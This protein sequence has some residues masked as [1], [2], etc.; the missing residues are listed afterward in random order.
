MQVISDEQDTLENVLRVT[1][2]SGDWVGFTAQ[3]DPFQF[4]AI[5]RLTPFL[6]T[7]PT[8][9]QPVSNCVVLQDTLENSLMLPD[10]AGTFC[11]AQFVPF[12]RSASGTPLFE[13]LTKS[14]T[15]VQAFAAVHD[16]PP[17]KALRPPLG[18]G[19]FSIVQD[20]PSHCSAQVPVLSEPVAW[21]AVA[22][23]Q[24]T[25]LSCGIWA[26]AGTGVFLITHEVPFQCSAKGIW[27]PEPSSD[28][29]TA[30]QL[31]TDGQD[32]LIRKLLVTPVGLGVDWAVQVVPFQRRASV[33]MDPPLRTSPT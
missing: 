15:A 23:V 11:T 19:V 3:V 26:P 29:P 22:D 20:V 12:H 16:T 10:G 2:G 32:T 7:N 4:S 25:P 24:D 21:H 18:V 27:L 33:T 14:P 31:F 13:A 30:M 1:L 5:G 6:V 28:R 9:L 8:A 17:R